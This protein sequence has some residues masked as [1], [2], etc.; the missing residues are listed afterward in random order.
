MTQSD[1]HLQLNYNIIDSIKKKQ[2]LARW[3]IIIKGCKML[4][5]KWGNTVMFHFLKF[6]R[7]AY[8]DKF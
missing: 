4:K 5:A 8:K 7:V 2:S 6:C 3:K 1:H